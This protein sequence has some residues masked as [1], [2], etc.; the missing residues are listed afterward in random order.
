MI[1]P[2]QTTV[3]HNT[4]QKRFELDLPGGLSV[5]EYLLGDE[6][7]LHP[8]WRRKRWRQG[9]VPGWRIKLNMLENTFDEVPQ[10]SF[11]AIYR[12]APGV[13]GTC[14][15]EGI[16]SF[17]RRDGLFEGFIHVNR[18]VKSSPESIGYRVEG[19]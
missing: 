11:I 5:L 15:K 8:Y 17:I 18:A 13:P 16:V 6:N 3:T 10:C 2:G 1:D 7:H 12:K 4:E 14:G 9:L 19:H